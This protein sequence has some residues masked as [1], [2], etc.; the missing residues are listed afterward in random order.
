VGWR[1]LLVQN[2][3][4][5]P[6]FW[7]FPSHEFAQF[8]QDFKVTKLIYRLAAGNPLCHYNSMDIEENNEHEDHHISSFLSLPKII[9]A[10]QKRMHETCTLHRKPQLIIENF[11]SQITQE[12]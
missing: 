4:V 9:R 2:P 12:T 1:V 8:H 3:T 11:P 7:S 6:E 10:I 5:P